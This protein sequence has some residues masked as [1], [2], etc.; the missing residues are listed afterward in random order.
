MPVLDFPRG[1]RPSS[2]NLHLLWNTSSFTAPFTRQ[3]QTQE[4]PGAVWTLTLGFTALNQVK[5]RTLRA[6]VA[7][8][9]GQAGRI[10]VGPVCRIAGSSAPRLRNP[11]ITADLDTITADST[12]ITADQ[13]GGDY[14]SFG[15]PV[16]VSGSGRAIVS[17]GWTPEWGIYPA[18][19]PGDYFSVNLDPVG[20]SMH[21]V[22]EPVLV[23]NDGEA[24]IAFEPPLRGNAMEGSPIEFKHPVCTMRLVDDQQGAMD[25]QPGVFA[26]TTLSFVESFT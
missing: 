12:L 22:T 24:T 7:Q 2:V 10:N 3:V 1:V 17:A 21:I 20:K 16:V 11:F 9:R 25:Y 4:L 13:S 19:M 18:L 14:V 6:L 5:F 8:L 15:D 26:N 23:N